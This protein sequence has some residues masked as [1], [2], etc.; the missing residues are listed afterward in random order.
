MQYFDLIIT[1][2]AQEQIRERG[3]KLD[4]VY[5]AFKHPTRQFKN[6][7]GGQQFEHEF[8]DFKITVIAILNNKNEWVAKSAWR[9]PT[10]P[11]TSDAKQKE[12]WKKYNRSN[13]WRKVWISIK[14][15]LGLS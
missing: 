12:S 11:G 3:L 6:K 10:L 9:N 5:E 14:Q 15:Q 13:M 4:D 2:H 7:Y 8:G 1:N